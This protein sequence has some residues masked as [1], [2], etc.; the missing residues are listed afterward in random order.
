MACLLSIMES[1]WLPLLAV[2]GLPG[3]FKGRTRERGSLVL[4]AGVWDLSWEGR[5]VKT[6]GTGGWK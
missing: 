4:G 6:V 1:C 3:A 5:H 2:G